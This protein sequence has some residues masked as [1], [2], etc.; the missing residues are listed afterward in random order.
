MTLSK[1]CLI[2]LVLGIIYLGGGAMP[3]SLAKGPTVASAP[4]PNVWHIVWANDATIP[5]LL[6]LKRM[7]FDGLF[8]CV[9]ITFD[10]PD[11]G[12][13]AGGEWRL[14]ERIEGTYDWGSMRY[15]LDNALAANMWFIPEIV[16]N[17]PPDW[18]LQRYPGALLRDSRGLTTLD[19]HAEGAP[20]M[21][22]PWFIDSGSADSHLLPFMQSFLDL[23]AQY[24]NVPAIMVG[25]FKLN[26]LPWKMGLDGT[27]NFTYWPIWD[28]YA[29]A[30]YA[31]QFGG[32][33]SPPATWADYAAM[34]A[35]RQTVFRGWLTAAMGRNLR[36][37]YLPWVADFPGWVVV[38]AAMWNQDGVRSSV[39]T[40]TT[41]EMTAAKQA[42]IAAAGLPWIAIDDDN[43]GDFGLARYQQQDVV[44]AHSYGFRILGERVPGVSTWPDMYAMWARFSPRADGFI[45][46]ETPDPDW[47]RRFR[48]LY[49][50]ATEPLSWRLRLPLI[51]R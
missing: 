39:F 13:F 50:P 26:V 35:T 19:R 49:G 21:L 14:V 18:F 42:A 24:P 5:H 51:T 43:M 25:N 33:A 1:R 40:T 2:S 28:D 8:K 32:G 36:T 41:P 11:G 47:I 30:D 9:A 34:P 10:G 7:G 16:I 46:I 15:C 23:V 3:V 27:D 4:L 29:R 22:S 38:N 20:Y 12:Q 37:R 44:L 45:N 48:E 6:D 31:R 17:V